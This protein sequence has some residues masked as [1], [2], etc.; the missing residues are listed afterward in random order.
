M[1]QILD[2]KEIGEIVTGKV[3]FNFLEDT[4]NFQVPIEIIKCGDGDGGSFYLYWLLDT[5]ACNL[6]YCAE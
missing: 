5:P 3:C 4:C 2:I 1:V 6:R